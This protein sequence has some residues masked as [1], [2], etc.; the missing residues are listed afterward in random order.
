M[1]RRHFL[2]PK[3]ELR[4][5]RKASGKPTVARMLELIRGQVIERFAHVSAVDVQAVAL[6]VCEPSEEDPPANPSHPACVAF[7]SSDYCRESW[8]LH[9]AKLKRR[10]ETHWGTCQYERLCA[11]IPIVCGNRC[12]AVVKLAGPAS[13]DKSEFKRI[14]EI[15]ELLARDF[16]VSHE[17]FLKRVPGG[18]TIEETPEMHARVEDGNQTAPVATHP[19]VLRAL[20]YIAA[21]LS[22]PSLTVGKVASVLGL[23]PTYLSELFVEQVG[24]RMSRF[25]A[26]RRIELARKLLA[27]TEWQIKRIA[28]ETGHAN[29]NWFCHVFSAHTG[30]TPGE[31][32]AAAR[33]QCQRR[34]GNAEDRPV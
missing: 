21:H 17:G 20:Q 34:R 15:M 29:P 16:G 24:Q 26:S 30:L 1:A 5:N 3:Q 8:Q 14:M 28:L 7:A 2:H 18:T 11:M 10:P 23:C 25:I 9:L 31:Y 19:Q 22:E 13:L 27:T 4:A 12:L 33:S 6:A 32:R